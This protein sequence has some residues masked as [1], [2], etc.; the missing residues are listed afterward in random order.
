MTRRLI[1]L[2]PFPTAVSSKPFLLAPPHGAL[3]PTHT[4]PFFL[5][6]LAPPPSLNWHLLHMVHSTFHIWIYSWLENENMFETCDAF[7]HYNPSVAAPSLLLPLLLLTFRSCASNDNDFQ[8]IQCV[9]AAF[10]VLYRYPRCNIKQHVDGI[11]SLASI[12]ISTPFLLNPGFCA[13][14]WTPVGLPGFCFMV[15]CS[16]INMLAVIF[17]A[18]F[19]SVHYLPFQAVC[20]GR[21]AAPLSVQ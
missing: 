10:A 21:S 19:Y 9:C 8:G 2:L 1:A 12:Q 6:F 11:F 20:T 4:S 18:S 16:G 17:Q 5:S 15:A 14:A 13:A 3:T 7:N